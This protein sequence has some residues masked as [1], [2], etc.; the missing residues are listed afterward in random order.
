APRC[1]A[2]RAQ[3]RALTPARPPPPLARELFIRHALVEGEWRTTHRFFHANRELLAEVGELEHR[4]RRRDIVVDDEALFAFYDRRIPAEGVSGRHSDSG[5]KRARRDRPALLD[6][7]AEA[8]LTERAGGV[9]EADYPG[10]WELAGLALPLA[11]HFEPGAPD[12]GVTVQIPLGV[13]NRVPAAPFSWNVPGLREELVT[14]LIRA[15]PK[16]LRHA[17]VPV[18]DTVRAVL[19]RLAVLPGP[20]GLPEPGVLP[21][22]EVLPEPGVLPGPEGLPG[23]GGL[24]GSGGSRGLLTDALSAELRA[25]T[26]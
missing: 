21:E 1:A 18:P 13:L 25:L 4:V 24:P 22:P 3:R 2:A 19:P 23:L 11:Y 8:L 16:Q 9:R 6:F 7:T 17:Y 5:W 26:G 15:L 12:D 14:A 10:R 20:E